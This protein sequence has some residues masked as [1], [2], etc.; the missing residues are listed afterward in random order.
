MKVYFE[1]YGCALNK[2]DTYIMMT[3][4]KDRGH[5]VTGSQEDA[6]VIV[7]NTCD[8]RLETGERMKRRIRQLSNTGKKLVVAGCFSGAE[9][10]VVRSIAPNAS[11]LGPQAISKIVEAVE[12]Q[13]RKVYLS[14]DQPVYT[15][16]IAEGKIGV[17]PV[18]DGCA[19]DCNFCI[20]KLARSKLRS[21]PLR[22]IVESA[23]A[24]VS[25]G[26]VEIEITGQDAAAYGLDYG[27]KI[28]LADVVKEV[29][30]VEGE[31]MIRVGMMTPEQALRILDDLL[32]AYKSPKVYKFFHL[33][34]QSGDDGVLKAMNRKYTVDEYKELVR[35]IRRK[36]PLANITTDIIVGHPGEDEGAFQN[37]LDLVK[38]IRFEK[39]HI[40]IYSLRPNTKS[41]SMPQ[42]PDKVK[43]E[44][45]KRINSL[46]EEIARQNHSEYL[47]KVSKVVVTEEGKGN[48][49]IGRTVNYI[50]VIL[51]DVELG[52]WYNVK[53]TDF[54]FYDV[55]GIVI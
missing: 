48:T 7:I 2:G 35:E 10:A 42:I 13:E 24:L 31:F 29:S 32:E 4:I 55:R 49:K 11:I 43:T 25:Q 40:A 3:L 44:R 53:I 17:I 19:G 12:S 50:P 38:E 5:E 28:T 6:D 52:K 54:S 26:V 23:K 41:S 33:P 36:I 22:K 14:S 51:E 34:V 37:T 20:T 39:M 18:A 15:P 1:T 45:L 9:P 30:E 21:Y 27:G 46:Y 16:R 47:G 8:V